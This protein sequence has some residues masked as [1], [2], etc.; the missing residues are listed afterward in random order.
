MMGHHNMKSDPCQVASRAADALEMDSVGVLA[1][2]QTNTIK[3]AL[4]TTQAYYLNPT[5]LAWRVL[6]VAEPARSLD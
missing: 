2:D 6:R 3:R 4:S 5:R 1:D